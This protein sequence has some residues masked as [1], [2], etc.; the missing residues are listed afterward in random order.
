MTTHFSDLNNDRLPIHDLVE[1]RL[2]ELGI[3][4][5][6]F[7]RRCG[8]KN[9]AKGIRRIEAMCSGDLDSAPSR[10]ILKALPVAL[11]VSDDIVSAAVRETA[12][13]VEESERKATAERDDA[14]RASF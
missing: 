7:A 11:E 14:W 9:I 1:I 4:R 10:M 6:E 8:F 3:R 2:R 5:N 12:A 13:S